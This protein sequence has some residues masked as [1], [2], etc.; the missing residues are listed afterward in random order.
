MG[1][2][3]EGRVKRECVRQLKSIGAVY[4]YPVTG[5]YGLSGVS[6]I[7]VCHKGN[8]IAIECK[9]GKAKPTALQQLFLDR[10]CAAGGLALVINE[11]NVMG[12][13]HMIEVW[14][15]RETSKILENN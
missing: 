2:T 14:A 5:G 6:D 3:A 4:F 8:Y 13:A 10:V 11:D 7:I 9:A 15:D 1:I 12:L